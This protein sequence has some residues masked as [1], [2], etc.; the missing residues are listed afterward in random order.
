MKDKMM[1]YIYLVRLNKPIGI[2]LLL[3]PTLWALLLAQNHQPNFKIITVFV[4]GVL[5]MRSA[6]CIINDIADRNFDG[7]V[8]RT[9]QRPLVSKK[10]SVKNALCLFTV[11]IACAF[12][13]V[14]LLNKFTIGLA[15]AG[16]GLA[17]IYPFLK[18]VTHLPQVGLGIAF[19]WG[20]P[21][22]FA[23]YQ[24]DIPA[25]AWVLFIAA[26]IWP[27]IYDTFY[28]M[29]DRDDDLKAGV[30]STAILF[31]KNDKVIIGFLQVI[32]LVLMVYVGKIFLLNYYYFISLAI[33]AM[34]F[35]YQQIMIKE[36]DPAQ[37][38]KAFLH[39]NWVGLT[40]FSGIVLGGLQ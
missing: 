5:I 20:I 21:M 25:E 6:G 4:L 35:L 29:T 14:L 39:N 30:K 3:W 10:L 40:I 9:K 12:F 28:A 19:S 15:F 23:A 32:F 24:N 31:N 17:T 37:C 11:L 22:A 33:T 1:Q 2:L 16:L 13:L 27:V 38:F 8:A 36:R 34:L 18:R 26:A 7:F